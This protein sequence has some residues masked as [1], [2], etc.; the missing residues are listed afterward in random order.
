MYKR[1]SC[2]GRERLLCF[3]RISA[4]RARVAN[5]FT[6][7][8]GTPYDFQLLR[9]LQ[10]VFRTALECAKKKNNE[11]NTIARVVINALTKS[12]RWHSFNRFFSYSF[13]VTTR[14]VE[15]FTDLFTCNLKIVVQIILLRQICARTILIRDTDNVA[16]TMWLDR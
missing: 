11:I 12:T 4:A 8:C 6:M 15:A 3:L 2:R 16:R 9:V 14:T 5:A 13:W 1:C 7:L 10:R